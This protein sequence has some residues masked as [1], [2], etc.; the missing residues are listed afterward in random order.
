MSDGRVLNENNVESVI[1][2]DYETPTRKGLADPLGV[3]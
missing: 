3:C 1:I 2:N